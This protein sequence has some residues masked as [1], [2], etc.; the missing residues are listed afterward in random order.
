[1]MLSELLGQLVLKQHHTVLD[2]YE[3]QLILHKIL[4]DAG[5]SWVSVTRNGRCWLIYLW[6]VKNATQTRL[7]LVHSVLIKFRLCI[8]VDTV[9]LKQQMVFVFIA[10]FIFL[11]FSLQN[12]SECFRMW[13]GD[14]VPCSSG[15]NDDTFNINA[16]TI[17]RYR[18]FIYLKLNHQSI[19]PL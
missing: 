6:Q 17:F 12:C 16:E 9:G 8:Q 13:H 3:R 7:S 10:I 14:C 18:H 19:F 1:M 11:L 2:S 4:A 5:L 15:S